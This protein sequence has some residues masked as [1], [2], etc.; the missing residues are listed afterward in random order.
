[1]TI[2]AIAASVTL[3]S[4][5]VGQRARQAGDLI[6]PPRGDDEI[7][8]RD[9]EA[10]EDRQQ[11]GERRAERREAAERLRRRR[12]MAPRLA[13]IELP[14]PR[15]ALEED[16][17]EDDGEHDERDL[18]RALDAHAHRPGRVD[19]DGQRAD[20][21]EFRGADVVQRLHQREAHAD[22][23]RRARE[24]HR[25]A[26]EDAEPV[27]AERARHF[28]RRRRLHQEERADRQIDVGVEHDA[29]QK[30]AAVQRADLREP[31]IAR[32]RDAEELAERR[33]H[34]PERMQHV[35]IGVGDDVGR[36]GERQEQRPFE[37]ALA[38]KA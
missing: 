37:H 18:R 34:R 17:R 2:V 8:R 24:R 15:P 4:I 3:F 33:L 1:M 23:D 26:E 28:Q 9:E 7:A 11:A 16:Q 30:D 20:A 25:D 13:G 29:E 27:R 5:H 22:G 19:R 10:E 36:D 21:E 12:V 32:A 31:E 6:A 14:P 38:R 35:E